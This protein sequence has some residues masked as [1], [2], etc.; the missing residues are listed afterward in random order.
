MCV[1]VCVCVFLDK[2]SGITELTSYQDL[3][4]VCVFLLKP[5]LSPRGSQECLTAS[6]DTRISCFLFRV[7]FHADLVQAG[8]CDTER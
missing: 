3:S 8:M 1:C 7:R 4:V 6:V 2:I 5:W